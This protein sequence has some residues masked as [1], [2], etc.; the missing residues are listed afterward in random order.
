MY[1]LFASDMDGTLLTTDKSVHPDTLKA[2][3]DA[4]RR[5]ITVSYCT[6][7]ALAE[8][9]PYI[10][11]LSPMRYGVCLCGAQ[12]YDFM[13]SRS[14]Y[15]RPVSS[16]FINRIISVSSEYDAMIQLLTEDRS[17][18]RCDQID[19]M[20]DYNLKD[21]QSMFK[22]IATCVK[23]IREAADLYG[24]MLKA[25][26]HFHTPS[27][28]QQAY[29]RLKDLPLSFVFSETSTLE[30]M[31][32]GVSKASGLAMLAKCLNIPMSEVMAIGDGNNDRQ[33]LLS[34]G[35]SVAMGNSG[36]ELKALSDAVTGDNDHDGVGSAIRKYTSSKTQ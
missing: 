24:E 1:K 4:V 26:I 34:A 3:D 22:S 35:F 13:E 25:N 21:Y 5:G 20:D 19:H 27:A 33:M 7:R 12:I 9:T 16:A 8:L 36:S 15:K 30:I 31:A 6:G 2:I 18:V 29:D 17:I 23:D 28:R 10:D 32:G 11:L 14:I